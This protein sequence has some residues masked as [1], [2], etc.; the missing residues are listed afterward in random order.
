MRRTLAQWSLQNIE[1]FIVVTRREQKIYSDWL[2][3][4]FE[5]FHFVPVAEKAIPIEWQEVTDEPFITLQGSAHRDFTTFFQVIE[6]LKIKTIVASSPV[7]LDGM[8]IPNTVET[9]FGI[10]RKECWKIT[11]QSRFSV[12]PMH[13]RPDIPAAGIVTIVEAMLMER[14]VI[15]T[16]CNGAEDYIVDGKTGFL[17]EPNSPE[18]MQEAIHTLWSDDALRERMSRAAKDYAECHFSYQ[19]GAHSLET[20]LD[21]VAQSH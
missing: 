3:L 15:A 1:R 4:P 21:A 18:Q 5:K 19:A 14:P 13:H 2:G 9:P 12:V 16:R 17:V 7:A 6:T 11:Q 20:I 10:S 8:D